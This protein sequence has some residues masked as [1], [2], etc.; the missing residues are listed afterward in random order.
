MN[1]KVKDTLWHPCSVDIIEHV[2]VT[3]MESEGHSVY[4]SRAVRNVGVCG[5]VGVELSVD[6]KGVVRFVGLADDYENDNGLQDLVEGIYYRTRREA[7]IA[8]YIIQKSLTETNMNNT[9]CIYQEAKKSYDT[10]CRILSE[11][12]KGS[13]EE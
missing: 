2:V 10:C 13:N 1:L 9:K 6:R 5:R 4:V 7:R 12:D 3:K 11:I 8:Y